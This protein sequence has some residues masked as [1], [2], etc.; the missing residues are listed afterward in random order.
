MSRFSGW[1]Y[2]LR[3]LLRRNAADRDMADEIEFHVERQTRKHEASGLSAEDARERALREFGGTTRWREEARRARGSTPLD[4][5]EHALR[6]ALR[7]LRRNPAFATLAVVTLGLAIGANAAMFGIID[8][9]LLRGPEYLRDPDRVVRVYVPRVVSNGNLVTSA[10]QPYALYR[11]ARDDTP[12]F[13]AVAA[14]APYEVAAG[15]GVE[16]RRVRVT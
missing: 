13:S 12:A 9:M 14:Y 2:T 5:I 15:S 1:L 10:Y 16:S 4:V 7:N 8:R 3:S 11:G 6:H